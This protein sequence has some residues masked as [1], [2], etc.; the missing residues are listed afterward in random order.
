MEAESR[1]RERV[2]P[3]RAHLDVDV[4]VV[5]RHHNH[6]R[7]R[8]SSKASQSQATL[9]YCTTTKA[10]LSRQVD[11]FAVG[12]PRDM[13]HELLHDQPQHGVLQIRVNK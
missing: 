6:T 5:V 3:R 10:H 2:A 4:D 1:L 13:M 7:C 11:F 12:M 9:L 8:C